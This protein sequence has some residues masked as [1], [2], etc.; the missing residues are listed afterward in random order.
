MGTDSGFCQSSRGYDAAFPLF[1]VGM[2]R[3]GTKLLRGIL[4]G[5][6]QVVVSDIETEFLPYWASNWS[7]FGPL[8]DPSTFRSFYD[9]FTAT[10]YHS[11]MKSRGRTVSCNDWYN[12]CQDYSVSTVFAALM[13]LTLPFD[14][15]RQRI[16]GDKSPSYISHLPLIR[17]L[18]P[19]ARIVH[20]V[21]DVRDYCVSIKN[22]W[23]K[24]IFR[25]AQRWSNDVSAAHE[26]GLHSPANY[27]EIRYEDLLLHTESECARL[28]QFLD[29]PFTRDMIQLANPTEN[30]GRTQGESRIV[31]SNAG[32]YS[33]QL[34]DHAITRIEAVAGPVMSEL[35]YPRKTD[36]PPHLIGPFR[37][38]LYKVLDGINLVARDVEGR[39]LV[40]SLVFYARYH[41]ITNQN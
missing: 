39:G 17:K 7:N 34:S 24:N 14:A 13:Q 27:T 12:A 41:R 23:G 28:C 30:L 20:I 15:S 4:N 10:P 18:Y 40:K 19:D 26:F 29:I 8:D 25:A 22:A 2:P 3:S 21:R 35:G 5:H 32:I 33:T 11:Y 9:R 6:P 31:S 1:I 37:M 38:F 16:W 36:T